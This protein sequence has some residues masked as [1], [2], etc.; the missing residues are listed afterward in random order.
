MPEVREGGVIHHQ[1]HSSTP[2]CG[3]RHVGS[4]FNG[5]VTGCLHERRASPLDI[6]GSIVIGVERETT[7]PTSEA[8]LALSACFVDGS[9]FRTGLRCVGGINLNQRPAALL[10][11]VG[12]DALKRAPS[13]F[14]NASIEAA[15][16]FA[17]SRHVDDAK[18]LQRD[19]AEP[20]RYVESDLVPPVGSATGNL[21]GDPAKPPLLL[22]VTDRSSDAAR[23]N[24]LRSCF[25]ALQVR[26]VRRGQKLSGG[27]RERVSNA[28]IDAN[29]RECAGR[30]F[31]LNG[32]GK[33]H[34]PPKSCSAEGGAL[35]FAP[36]FS[37]VAQ[38]D[39]AKV[40]DANLCPAAVNWPNA[41]IVKLAPKAVVDAPLARAWV[42]ALLG[43]KGGKS[44]IEIAQ[45][46]GERAARN[47][48]YPFYATAELGHFPRLR[49]T[50][51]ASSTAT[52]HPS[53]FER[54]IIHKA[55]RADDLVQAIGLLFGR[56][57]TVLE[58]A[59][60]H[61]SFLVSMSAKNNGTQS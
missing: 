55:G 33:A 30:G 11:F 22:P 38:F 19:R 50:I 44:L 42:S 40:R 31:V 5:S 56:I 58:R 34:E 1:A 16:S 43:E 41:N 39:P 28:S 2:S 27:Q 61:V 14:K 35:N 7:V 12:Q 32:G 8:G 15:L 13:L 54:K 23:E 49:E 29:A 46:A 18:V 51:D 36:H 59:L 24:A 3:Y 20:L 60:N 52:K 47:R 57:K 6:D 10:Q 45:G 25:P 53:L 37:S 4:R 9:T 21:G 48:S 17:G 26:E